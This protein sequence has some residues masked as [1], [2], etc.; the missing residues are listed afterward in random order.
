A[1]A[2]VRD[3]GGGVFG[4]GLAAWRCPAGYLGHF[5]LGSRHLLIV[6]P[7][8]SSVPATHS[9]NPA[10]QVGIP[11]LVATWV[12]FVHA[13]VGYSPA[14]EARGQGG[15]PGVLRPLIESP[16]TNDAPRDLNLLVLWRL[17]AASHGPGRAT[18]Q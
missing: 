11:P 18:T 5:A 4:G 12:S 8:I 14:R 1:G 6:S 17:G 13:G 16:D 9:L 7:S 15:R 10:T 2:G 3:G